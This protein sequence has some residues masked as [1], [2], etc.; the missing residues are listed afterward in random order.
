[1]L[2]KC[3]PEPSP[4]LLEYARQQD[5]K[6][7]SSHNEKRLHQ[8]MP[9]AIPATVQPV[10][11]SLAPLG[12]PVT[13]VTSNLSPLGMTLHTEAWPGGILFAVQLMIDGVAHRVLVK[14]KW[15]EWHEPFVSVGVRVLKQFA[16]APD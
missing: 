7:I 3:L 13:A 2:S 5:G 10:S 8:R 1:M 6:A 9:A 14:E 12:N 11:Y 4:E 15:C 16:P